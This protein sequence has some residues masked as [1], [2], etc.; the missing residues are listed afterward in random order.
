MLEARKG[1]GG[2]ASFW[3]TPARPV[4]MELILPL[5]LLGV[6]AVFLGLSVGWTVAEKP[7]RSAMTM[8]GGVLLT[9]IGSVMLAVCLGG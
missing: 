6:G 9:P 1:R 7:T 3:L 4:D 8:A 2:D 5:L